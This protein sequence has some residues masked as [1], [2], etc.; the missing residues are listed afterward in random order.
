MGAI[1]GRK[2]AMTQAYGPDGEL[3]PVTIVEAGP[4][5]VVSTRTKDKDGY[6][7]SVLGFEQIE[8]A[9]VRKSLLGFFKKANTPCFRVTREFRDLEAQPGADLTVAQFKDGDTLILEGTSKGKG[10]TSVIKKWNYSRGR[11]SHGGNCKRKVGS[12]GMHTWPAH[13]IKGKKMPG[14]W[15]NE[16]ITLRSAEVVKVIAEDNLIL[17]KGAIPGVPNALV[18][19]RTAP[20]KKKKAAA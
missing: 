9:K 3:I 19:L 13:V 1:L 18:S 14:R 6:V 15:G 20:V 11:M 4:C 8:G 5:K 7:A 12:T 16:S 2:V 17:I 10:M